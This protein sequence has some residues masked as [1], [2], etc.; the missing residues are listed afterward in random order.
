MKIVLIICSVIIQ[1]MFLGI[2]LTTIL[3]SY[4]PTSSLTNWWRRNIIT[5]VDLEDNLPPS[6]ESES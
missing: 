6:D 2:L 3:F 1:L 5:D 4:F